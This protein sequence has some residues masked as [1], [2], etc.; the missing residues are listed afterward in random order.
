MTKQ[1][2]VTMTNNSAASK[3]DIKKIVRCDARH[4]GGKNVIITIRESELEA[5]TAD[6]DACHSVAGYEIRA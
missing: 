4:I 3:L 6:M 5:V 1:I 2:K